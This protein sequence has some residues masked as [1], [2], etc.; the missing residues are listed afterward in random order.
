MG[1][2]CCCKP[3]E[4]DEPEASTLDKLL[5]IL[6][7][8]LGICT[9]LLFGVPFVVYTALNL[10]GDFGPKGDYWKYRAAIANFKK[11]LHAL[12]NG[13]RSGVRVSQRHS[14][15]NLTAT[16]KMI[17]LPAPPRKPGF[18]L[19]CYGVDDAEDSRIVPRRKWSKAKKKRERERKKHCRVRDKQHPRPNELA[20]MMGVINDFVRHLRRRRVDLEPCTIDMFIEGRADGHTV[21]HGTKY[22]GAK[23]IKRQYYDQADDC[24]E[25]ARWMVLKTDQL[26]DNI[27]IAFLRAYYAELFLKKSA[28][29]PYV[30]RSRILAREDCE[31]GGC[32]RKVVLTIRFEDILRRE[33][34]RLF[35]LTRVWVWLKL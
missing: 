5:E 6:T 26:I 10:Y 28:L 27:D 13:R 12:Q 33:F 9:L 18:E 2:C 17:P 3:D 34:D 15:A 19:G 31:R 7:K 1:H 29:Q 25:S 30:R 22:T 11:A 35:W 8:L 14:G 21:K 32:Y 16:I 4:P 20:H 24:C 23:N